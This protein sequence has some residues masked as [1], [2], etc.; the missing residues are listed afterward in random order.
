MAKKTPEWDGLGTSPPLYAKAATGS[1]VTWQCWVRGHMVWCQWGQE[2]GQ[3][4]Q[5]SFACE[6]K[7]TGR[8]NATTAGEQAIKEAIAKWKKQ[9]K[10]KYHVNR[11]F[12]DNLNVKPMLAKDFKGRKAKIE[13]PVQVQPKYDG[14]RCLAFRQNGKVI[15]QSRGG[16]P[17]DVQH[18]VD[19]LERVLPEDVVLDGELYVH[20]MSL[21]QITSLVKK[22]K[23]DSGL[24]TYNVYDITRLSVQDEIWST[25]CRR[26]SDFFA[27]NRGLITVRQCQEF[28]ALNEDDV[29][30]AHDVFVKQGYEGAII[31]LPNGVYRFGYRSSE[32]LKLK[33]FKDAEFKIVGWAR[34]KGKFHNVPTFRCVTKKGKEFDATPVGNETHRRA[35]LKKA[36]K[37]IGK[38][39]TVKFFDYTDDGIPHFP[40][41][42]GV[43]DPGT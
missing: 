8:A 42:L 18:I 15:L 33:D 36:D 25:R 35:L 37:L 12:V 38:M 2:G 6:A 1:V 21:Q 5:S 20:G 40:V 11:S 43:R 4:Q 29:K 27:M 22:P 16:D 3:M 17:Y 31:R 10:K 23:E 41:A 14:V 19:E 24:L 7:N 39:L 13:Y 28:S 9:I 32:L 26:K 34:G 30:T